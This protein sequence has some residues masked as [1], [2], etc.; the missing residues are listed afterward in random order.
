MRQLKTAAELLHDKTP[1]LLR[2]RFLLRFTTFVEL[3]PWPSQGTERDVAIIAVH[4][5]ERV[6]S[7]PVE[8]PADQPEFCALIDCVWPFVPGPRRDP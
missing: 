8:S 2:G 6:T 7:V 4:V 1:L 3:S 5:S